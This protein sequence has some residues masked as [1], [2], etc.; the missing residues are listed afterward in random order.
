MTDKTTPPEERGSGPRVIYR[1]PNRTAPPAPSRNLA[2]VLDDVARYT[3]R[4]V[5][6]SDSQTRACALWVAHCHAFAV[7]E[8]TPY[9]NVTSA[10][11]QSGKT[12][13]L[14]VLEP[15]VPAPWLTGRVSAAVL[16]RKVDGETPTLLLDESDAVFT[17]HSA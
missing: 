3:R 13:L 15:L 6:L 11:K 10:V 12:R 9:L 16:T 5:V 4:Y 7:A 17:H 1:W 14:E 8:A 2:R